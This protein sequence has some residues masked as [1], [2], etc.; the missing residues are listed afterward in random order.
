MN[1]TTCL[2]DVSWLAIAFAFLSERWL[3]CRRS[4][5]HALSKVFGDLC[6]SGRRIH[7]EI[8]FQKEVKYALW[9]RIGVGS[10]GGFEIACSRRDML[11]VPADDYDGVGIEWIR[12]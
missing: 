9:P 4:K 10:R 1:C 11:V 5:T 2:M 12:Q 6:D 8:E 7:A 3:R